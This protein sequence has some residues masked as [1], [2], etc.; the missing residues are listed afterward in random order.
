MSVVASVCMGHAPG[1]MGWPE[2]A[3]KEQRERLF[4]A[5][6]EAG[7]RVMAVEPDVL[8]LATSE[9]FANFFDI[10]PPFYLNIGEQSEGPAE[11]W[12]GVERRAVPG[13]ASLA[14]RMLE[15]SL[16][17]GFDIAYGHDL[18]LDHGSIIP[19]ELMA[20]H[21]E[22]PVI[23]IIVNGLCAPM[24][25]F[26]RCGEWGESLGELLQAAPERVAL[27]GC[28]GLSHWPGMAEQ[29]KISPVWDRA[30]LDGLTAGDRSVLTEPPETGWD[31]AGPGAH[32]LRAWTITGFATPPARAEVL[33]YE[34]AVAWGGGLAVV[35]LLPQQ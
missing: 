8:V 24:P 34:E 28:G 17:K 25:T 9:H 33:A 21:R 19:L 18:L 6:A 22:T 26:T 27:V 32:E 20:I 23:P 14:E 16:E 2:R 10:R 11:K 13:N 29:G 31:E 12:L 15:S 4:G 35:D 7:Q 5:I 1:M 3:P 30:V